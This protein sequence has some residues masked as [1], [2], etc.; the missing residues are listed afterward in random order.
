MR[1]PAFGWLAERHSLGAEAALVVGLYALYQTSRGLVVGDPSAAFHHAR[2]IVSLER[3]LHVFVE[4]H[5]QHA[6]GLLPGLLALLG[7]LYL[8]LHLGG[9]GAYLLWLHR[10]RPAAFP[11]VRNELL[12]ASAIALVGFLAYPTAPPRLAAV[13]LADTISRGDLS[14][15]HGL[16]SALYNP[17][18]AVPSIHI[19]YAM[20]VGTSLVRDGR[21]AASRV[22]GWVYPPLVLLVVVAT[23]NHF[24]FDAFL[25]AAIA[26]VVTAALAVPRAVGRRVRLPAP[27]E[28]WAPYGRAGRPR[29]GWEHRRIREEPSR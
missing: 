19:C 11:R 5:V 13:G 14:L 17:Y 1:R 26:V 10:R 6:A 23:G 20:I 4:P 21:S 22:I 9:T 24:F 27:S 25:G 28:A 8:T 29:A 12:A 15:D 7:I 18:A 2:S 3:S 16:V